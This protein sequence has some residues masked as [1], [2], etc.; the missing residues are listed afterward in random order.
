MEQ[1]KKNQNQK[2]AQPTKKNEMPNRGEN[3]KDI[4]SGPRSTRPESEPSSKNSHH[5]EDHKS[6]DNERSSR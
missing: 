3:K 5:R 6:N 4:S 1:N 2:V